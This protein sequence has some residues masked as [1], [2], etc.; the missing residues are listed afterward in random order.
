M[1]WKGAPAMRVPKKNS[2][3]ASDRD[4]GAGPFP[5]VGYLTAPPMILLYILPVFR[6]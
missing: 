1:E 2:V 5:D 4:E 3:F 6:S